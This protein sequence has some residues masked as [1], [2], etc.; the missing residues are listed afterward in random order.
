M[1]AAAMAQVNVAGRMK[2]VE[3]VIAE[4][5]AGKHNRTVMSR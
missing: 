1:F 2:T 5:V 3:N 4:N